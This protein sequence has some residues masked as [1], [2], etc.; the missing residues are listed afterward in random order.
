MLAKGWP[1]F[2]GIASLA[3]G[4]GGLIARAGDVETVDKIAA[5]FQKKDGP[6]GKKLAAEW[7]KKVETKDLMSLFK[8]RDKKGL[9]VG[10]KAGEIKPDCIETKLRELATFPMEE[11][12]VA[13]EADAL[14]TM[15]FRSVALAEVIA[16]KC[17][18]KDN[19]KK[20]RK[21]WLE[22][23]EELRLAALEMATAAKDKSAGTINNAAVKME[24]ACQ[25]CHEA[26]RD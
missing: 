14:R 13:M 9:G 17:P 15:A 25:K 16:A 21:D 2:V 26:F 20:K 8:P 22:W 12:Q 10:A 24:K 6:G 18:D 7:A 19:G 11:K 4:L 1:L 3:L 5:A 23:T